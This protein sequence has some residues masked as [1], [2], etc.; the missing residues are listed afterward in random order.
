MKMKVDAPKRHAFSRVGT[1]PLRGGVVARGRPR[2]GAVRRWHTCCTAGRL[3]LL[4]FSF[5]THRRFMV[6]GRRIGVVSWVDM[7]GDGW[8]RQQTRSASGVVVTFARRM[9]CL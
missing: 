4:I 7:A 9:P 5:T 2:A 3:H 6:F 8:R 1:S